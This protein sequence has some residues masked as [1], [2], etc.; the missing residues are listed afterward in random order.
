MDSAVGREFE[1][2]GYVDTE[3][4]QEFG[5]LEDIAE[6]SQIF[7][8]LVFERLAAFLW[9]IRVVQIV[10]ALYQL[11][12]AGQGCSLSLHVRRHQR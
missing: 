11:R 8:H 9:R 3:A 4:L 10:S 6:T 2:L 1:G 5:L 7:R 12:C